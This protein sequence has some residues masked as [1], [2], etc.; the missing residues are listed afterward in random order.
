MESLDQVDPRTQPSNQPNSKLSFFTPHIQISD[1]K[2]NEAQKDLS[3]PVES[4][5]FTNLN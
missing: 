3:S 5:F 2:L 4:P 1:D